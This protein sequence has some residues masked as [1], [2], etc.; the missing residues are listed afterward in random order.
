MV[1]HLSEI[2][3]GRYPG[4]YRRGSTWYVKKRVPIDLRLIENREQIA[5]SLGTT[6]PREAERRYPFCLADIERRF[7]ELRSELAAQGP[8]QAALR[9]GR[10]ELLSDADIESLVG[11]WFRK[12]A[13]LREPSFDTLDAR[14]LRD[15][16]ADGLSPAC[17]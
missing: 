2:D 5:I 1:Y 9:S 10:L 17:R 14:T 7:H 11:D 12:R 8:V 16:L 15:H 6:D 4:V 13:A 3:L